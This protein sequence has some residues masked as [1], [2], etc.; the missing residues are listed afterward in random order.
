VPIPPLPLNA[1]RPFLL[2]A[3]VAIVLNLLFWL[4]PMLLPLA[5]AVLL[6]FVLSRMVTVLHPPPCAARGAV[7]VVVLAAFA[8]IASSWCS[9]SS[10]GTFATGSSASSAMAA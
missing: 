9:C 3:S 4:Q 6:T 10:V 7:A 5:L 2:L 1:L 8:V